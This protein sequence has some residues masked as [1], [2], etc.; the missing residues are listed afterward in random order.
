MEQSGYYRFPAI[1]GD[2]IVFTAEDDLWSVPAAGGIARRLTTSLSEAARPVIS[3][4]GK[5]LAF[6][7]REEGNPELYAMPAVGG[8][9]RRLT[10]YGATTRPV[11]WTRD[12]SKILFAS[13]YGQPFVRTM[14]IFS[15]SPTGGEIALQPWGPASSIAVGANGGIVLGR[16]TSDPAIWK[17]YRGGTAGDL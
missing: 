14:Q 1:N 6:T 10:F 9:A 11:G 8:E 12:G 15:I 13:T 5:W 17:R 4:D 3:P 16:N 2:T 7:A